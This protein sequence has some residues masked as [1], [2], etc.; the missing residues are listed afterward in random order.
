MPQCHLLSTSPAFQMNPTLAFFPPISLKD[1]FQPPPPGVYGSQMTDPKL[2]VSTEE[3]PVLF[4]PSL[5]RTSIWGFRAVP[6][7]SHCPRPVPK[8]LGWVQ[9]GR[10]PGR[11]C[12]Q[13][14]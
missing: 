3:V 2:A 10:G 14:T 11:A 9:Q 4:S 13:P 6:P 8:G 12:E 1:P 5:V 7:G